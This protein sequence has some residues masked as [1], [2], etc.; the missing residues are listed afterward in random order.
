MAAWRASGL[1]PHQVII[2]HKSRSVLTRSD[3]M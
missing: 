3:F 2:W 1:L